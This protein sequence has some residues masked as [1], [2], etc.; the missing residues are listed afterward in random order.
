V[1][2]AER[3]MLKFIGHPGKTVEQVADHFPAFG[4]DRLIRAD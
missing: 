3:D 2:D 4:L 1:E